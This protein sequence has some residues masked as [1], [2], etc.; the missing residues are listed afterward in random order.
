MTILLT[1]AEADTHKKRVLLDSGVFIHVFH[2][3]SRFRN[4]RK[5]SRGD[6]I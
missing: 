6:Y 5:A 2:D 4:F 1:G 3:L